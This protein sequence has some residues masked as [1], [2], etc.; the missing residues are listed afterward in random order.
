MKRKIITAL[1][2]FAMTVVI[3]IVTIAL[4]TLKVETKMIDDHTEL[5]L[6]DIP[7]EKWDALAQKTIFFGHMSVGYNILDGVQDLLNENPAIGLKISNQPVAAAFCHAEAGSNTQPLK[8]IAS[9]QT[10][11]R[12]LRTPPDIAFLKFCYVDFYADTDAATIFAAY[13]KMVTDLQADFPE[14]TFM[15]C[16]VPLTT[17]PRDTKS[18]IKEVI[19]SVIG[20]TTTVDHNRKRLEFAAMVQQAYRPETI[21]DITTFESTTPAGQFH[22][23]NQNGLR[24][25]FLIEAYTTDGGHLNEAGRRRIA[26]QLLIQLANL[27]EAS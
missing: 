2:L 24:V 13:Q 3:L 8:K 26:E 6:Q 17:G 21:I 11:L 9:F 7:Q 10:Q 20:K 12:Q 22:F 5:T 25:P 19:K 14:T 1:L 18:Q 4:K 15:H 27:S 23:K 16:T